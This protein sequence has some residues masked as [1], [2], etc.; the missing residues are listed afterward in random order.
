MSGLKAVARMMSFFVLVQFLTMVK[1]K[2]YLIETADE[3]SSSEETELKEF[4]DPSGEGNDYLDEGQQKEDKCLC[5]LANRKTVKNR[6]VDGEVTE[7]NEYPW[8]VGLI[9]PPKNGDNVF[10]GGAL[11]GDRWVV[12]AGHCVEKKDFPTK[13]DEKLLKVT[14]GDHD[15]STEAE[16]KNTV[17]GVKGMYNNENWASS[18]ASGESSWDYALLELNEPVCFNHAIRPICLP[19]SDNYEQPYINKIAIVTGW[20][21]IKHRNSEASPVLKEAKVQITH[22]T[23]HILSIYKTGTHCSG[24]SGGPLIFSE[25][26][27]ITP[28][29]NYELIGLVSRGYCSTT[30]PGWDTPIRSNSTRFVAW[31]E[32]IT[33]GTLNSCPRI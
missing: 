30:K 8:Q 2:S 13:E 5:G 11:I 28:G 6:I 26:D 27:G 20:G 12:T 10:C 22:G 31:M 19:A 7:I 3:G 33:A 14:I 1:S 17:R 18:W 21:S 16:T 29:Q 32:Q 4:I 9:Y 24:D 15:Y 25:G 23:P